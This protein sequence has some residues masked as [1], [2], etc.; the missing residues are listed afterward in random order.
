MII[1]LLAGQI[2]DEVGIA[3]SQPVSTSLKIDDSRDKPGASVGDPTR[4]GI[5]LAA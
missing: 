5:I 3:N 4:S 1:L 2:D